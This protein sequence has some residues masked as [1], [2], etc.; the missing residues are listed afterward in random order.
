MVLAVFRKNLPEKNKTQDGNVEAIGTTRI[1]WLH[2]DV[3]TI[4]IHLGH[5]KSKKK[6]VVSKTYHILDVPFRTFDQF[7]LIVGIFEK[8]TY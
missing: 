3:R 8:I 7:E 1:L 6:L 4:W 5:G 2:L